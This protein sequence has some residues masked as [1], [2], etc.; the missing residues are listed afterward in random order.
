MLTLKG[1]RGF[2]SRS[3]WNPDG[4]WREVKPVIFP[5][6]NSSGQ[7]QHIS[8]TFRKLKDYLFGLFLSGSAGDNTAWRHLPHVLQGFTSRLSL[9]LLIRT[10]CGLGLGGEA[11]LLCESETWHFGH[12]QIQGKDLHLV[13][14]GSRIR[15][16]AWPQST[17][18]FLF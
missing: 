12:W 6:N 1:K 7:Q 14:R 8:L 18:H 2:N 5:A 11:T 10:R 4:T 13:H 9:L 16:W 17:F 3:L 15:L